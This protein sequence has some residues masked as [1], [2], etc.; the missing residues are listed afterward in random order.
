D[1]DGSGNTDMIYLGQS[2]FDFWLNLKGNSW[3]ERHQLDAFPK[4]DELSS[5]EVFDLLGSGTACVVWSSPLPGDARAPLKYIDIMDSKKPHL[6]K[7]AI[8][9]QGREVFFD[10]QPSTNF[11]LQDK[12]NGH[13]WVTRLPFPVHVVT[14]IVTV[15]YIRKTRYAQQY[16]YHHGYFDAKDREFR[17]FGRVEVEDTEDFKSFSVTGASNVVEETHHQPPSKTITWYHTGA[18]SH[19]ALLDEIY[20]DEF[21]DD[22]S[23][24]G[25][26]LSSSVMPPDLSITEWQESQRAFKGSV[27]RQEI[28]SKDGSL[29]QGIPYNTAEKRYKVRKVQ[30]EQEGYEAVFQV[31]GLESISHD[32]E[33]RPGDPKITQSMVLAHDDRGIPLRSASVNYPRQIRP[34]DLPGEIWALQNQ[35][36][37]TINEHDL[38]N[39]IETANNFRFRVPYETR[40]F[41]LL[42]FSVGS[43][44]VTATG[45]ANHLSL[46]TNIPYETDGDGSPQKRLFSHQRRYFLGNDLST[47][48]ALGD[49][50]SLALAHYSEQLA[51]TQGLVTKHYAGKVDLAMLLDAG[52]VHSE[53]DNNWWV[54]SGT[55]IYG[56]DPPSRFFMPEGQR[57][58]FGRE[59]RVGF[60]QYLLLI[61]N[62]TN[63]LGQ[64]TSAKNDYRTLTSYE[65]IDENL[66]RSQVETDILGCV[67]KKAVMGKAGA[68]E[69]DTLAEPTAIMEYELFN[70]MNHQRPNWVRARVREEHGNPG[71]VWQESMSHF[72][73]SGGLI[74]SKRQVEPGEAKRWDPLSQSVETVTTD[75]RWIGNGRSIVNN[76]G[77]PIKAFDPYFSTHSGF[78]DEAELVETGVSSISYFDPVGRVIRN[79][80]PDGTFTKTEFD[81]WQVRSFDVID[82][83]QDSDWYTSRGNPDPILDPEPSDPETRAAWLSAK[84]HNTPSITHFDSLRR[85][86]INFTDHG[87]GKITQV[88]NEM[89]L[90][91]RYSRVFDELDREVSYGVTNLI[92]VPIFGESAEKGT[93]WLFNDAMGRLY[94]LWDNDDR[95]FYATYDDLNRPLSAFV[96]Q[97]GIE[98]VHTHHVYGD[99]L[100]DAVAR[101]MVGQ[102]Y[103]VYDQAGVTTVEQNDFKL[104]PLSIDKQLTRNY[105]SL[106][107]W[108]SLVGLTDIAA[109]HAAAAPQLEPET[110]QGSVTYD[111]LNRPTRSV[112]A[113]G[114]VILPIYNRANNLDQLQ[115]QLG[116]VGSF[117]TFLQSQQHNVHGM[118]EKAEFGNGAVSEY[119]YDPNN[120]RLTR[121]LTRSHSGI[122]PAQ[123]LQDV[124]Y[125]YDAIGNVVE[126]RDLAQQTHYFNNA[127]VN[128]AAKFEYDAIHQLT[129]A[130]GREHA[131]IGSGGQ[132]THLDLP[133]IPQLPH[134]ND[135]NALRNY[136]EQY[137]YDDVGNITS[138]Q[139]HTGTGTGNW[140]R[141][142]Q[143]AYQN[144]PG[145]R[146]NRLVA[147]SRAG[148]PVTGPY[149]DQYH[150]DLRGNMISM[151]HLPSMQWNAMNQLTQVPLG[152]GG[153]AFY[154]YGASG[155]RRRKVIRRNGGQR[156]E[157]IYLGG[158]EIYRE[159][160][161]AG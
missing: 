117:R 119:S 116:G 87:G 146:T 16:S 155:T 34:P 38:T 96:R 154:V 127:V 91:G 130:T 81:I 143:Y 40:Q 120:F 109:I 54:P 2:R 21:F 150:Y 86:V 58:I 48:L 4:L 139:H 92:G 67:V 63:T 85:S 105:E 61:E 74:L 66:N 94:R 12:L 132:S 56:A 9:N 59:S 65:V 126:W 7:S 89:D 95:E 55:L 32:Y 149:S 131:G 14:K 97:D 68:G 133:Y 157:R 98:T 145:D 108:S 134:A 148:D 27:L 52:Y 71:S 64:S 84:Y 152:G 33:R 5:V 37:V 60:D 118:R 57:D 138:V 76:K 26:R 104:N 129:K 140:H 160:N 8:N 137:A 114:T 113:D 31:L 161:A 20:A 128:A 125:Y 156:I 93:S 144:S 17:G 82:T 142:Y 72:D 121:L 123:A 75:D 107:D 141:R 112:L 35:G 153:I 77:M 135:S 13:P 6:L 11:Y 22:H 159:Y 25:F 90:L 73:G 69:G 1:I 147:T 19:R 39:D 70:W 158:N 28:Y 83:V 41:E 51:F 18:F 10:Y 136:T 53:G 49:R 3:S 30:P 45:V 43:S 122:H 80:L 36:H 100:P 50:E 102:V 110:F 24:G 88:R 115:A 62:E 47:P 106:T 46:A 79:E 151:P 42:G 29:L 103:Q 101:N 15:D 111:A 124:R 44:L 23:A 99:G 78:E